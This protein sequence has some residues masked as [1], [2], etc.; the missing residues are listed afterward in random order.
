MVSL[1]GIQCIID[2]FGLVEGN[3]VL[4]DTYAMNFKENIVNLYVFDHEVIIW[5]NIH[6]STNIHIYK[7]QLN[8]K[9]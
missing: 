3:E 6:I 4:C 7:F 2:F 5:M 9:F 8:C 1:V